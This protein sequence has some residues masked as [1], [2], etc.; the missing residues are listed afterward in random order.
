MNDRE[1]KSAWD[2]L[3]EN[4]GT[5]PAA[6]AHERHQPASIDPPSPEV[7][8]SVKPPQPALSDWGGL[9]DALG[10]DRVESS[11]PPVQDQA[12]KSSEPVDLPETISEPIDSGSGSVVEHAESLESLLPLPNEIDQVLEEVIDE[13]GELNE[14]DE[15]PI[16]LEG[17]SDQTGESD[18][19]P[20][21]G[22][23]G[24]AARSAFDALFSSGAGQWGSAFIDTGKGEENQLGFEPKPFSEFENEDSEGQQTDSQLSDPPQAGTQAEPGEE[25]KPKR[26][27]SRR[28]RG[29]RSKGKIERE[30][31]EDS[32]TRAGVDDENSPETARASRRGRSR[33]KSKTSNES[34]ENAGLNAAESAADD[35]TDLEIYN[36]AE[37]TD[38]SNAKSSP[39]S[40]SAHRNLPTWAEAIGMIVDANLEQHGK[41]SSKPHSSRG[42]G[43]RG[44]RRRK[45]N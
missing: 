26:K 16:G 33:A 29:G 41:A 19:A 37:I 15:Q 8:E 25:A 12:V 9:A 43:G 13:F 22:I 6:D 18:D 21:P 34:A 11:A 2:S 14:A 23:T 3:A 38:N 24:D 35:D 17:H 30:A 5:Q 32:E 28:R 42:R 31:R 45:K 10:L 36:S 39:R 44:G 20:T 1:Q 40:R 27:R 4:L 7:S